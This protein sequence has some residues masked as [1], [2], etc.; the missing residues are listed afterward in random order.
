VKSTIGIAVLFGFTTGLKRDMRTEDYSI[1]D[2]DRVGSLVAGTALV[3][4]GLSRR[5]MRGI[6]LAAAGTPFVYRGLVGDWPRTNGARDDT[7]AALSGHRGIHVHESITLEKP[8]DEIYSFWRR[9][10]NLPRFMSNLSSV[11]ESDG[12]SHWVARG[13]G[14]FKVEWDAEIINDV[15]NKVIGWRSLPGADVISAGSVTFAP[16]RGGRSTQVSVNLQYEPPAGRAGAFV[17]TIAGRE[18][19]QTIR[20]DLRR[21]KQLIEAGE[22]PRARSES[23]T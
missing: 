1:N 15:Q 22:I 11:T 12:R 5:S 8:V 10:E 19:S 14:G 6:W 17:A 20:E 21:M 23:T 7:R 18:P 9:L 2:L 16:V 4:Y 13:P 3:A